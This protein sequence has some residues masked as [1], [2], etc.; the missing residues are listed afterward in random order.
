MSELRR[1]L[2]EIRAA[3]PAG[4][5]DELARRLGVCRDELDAMIGYWVHRGELVVE[6]MAGCTSAG[7][8]GCPMATAARGGC[9]GPRRPGV[10]LLSPAG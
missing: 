3:P 4:G 8:A 7:C 2:T 5:L 9:T 10:V 6:E 1:V